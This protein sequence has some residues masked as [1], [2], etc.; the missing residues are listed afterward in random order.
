MSFFETLLITGK[1]SSRGLT[2]KLTEN[3]KRQAGP[4]RR[5]VTPGKKETG[6]AGGRAGKPAGTTL[7]RAT[8]TPGTGPHGGNVPERRRPLRRRLF[9]LPL[10]PHPAAPLK[11]L[12]ELRF[13][14]PQPRRRPRLMAG[15][16]KI[17]GRSGYADYPHCRLRPLRE[18]D[19][20]HGGASGSPGYGHALNRYGARDTVI[21]I[22]PETAPHGG[23]FRDRGTFRLRRLFS[24]PL[25]YIPAAPLKTLRRLRL[26]GTRPRRRLR[27]MAGASGIAGHSGYGDYLYCRLWPHWENDDQHGG[28]SCSPG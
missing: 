18:N 19:V 1:K 25:T 11:T 21:M 22:T 26:S 28:S 6:Q 24:L 16:S 10:T 14:G 3:Q 8:A 7:L 27:L 15:A 4:Q 20:Q 23:N 17:A 5:S 12:R 13:S 9:S 2:G